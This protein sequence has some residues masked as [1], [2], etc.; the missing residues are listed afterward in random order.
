MTPVTSDLSQDP[1][2]RRKIKVWE[3]EE[4]S[5]TI[6]QL[7]DP[8]PVKVSESESFVQDK[9]AVLVTS[10][11]SQPG[12]KNISSVNSDFYMKRTMNW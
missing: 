11:R 5:E 3:E 1:E 6:L 12:T 9:E 7:P 8:V 4:K 10:P 2:L